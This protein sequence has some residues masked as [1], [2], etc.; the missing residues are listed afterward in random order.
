MI[1]RDNHKNIDDNKIY[2]IK[3]PNTAIVVFNSLNAG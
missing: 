3:K 2:L 1:Y